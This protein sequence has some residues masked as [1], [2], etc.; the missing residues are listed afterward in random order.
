MQLKITMHAQEKMIACGISID[1]IERAIAH[2]SKTKQTEGFL[3]CYLYYCI[4]YRIIG[5][6][7]YKIKTVYLR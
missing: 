7:I 3:S 5:K 2:G 6:N 1:D 4:A